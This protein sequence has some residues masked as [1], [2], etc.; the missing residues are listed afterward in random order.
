MQVDRSDNLPNRPYY[1]WVIVSISALTVLVVFGIRLSFTVFFVAL[2][3]E[4]GW[5][6]AGTSLIFSTGMVV[7]ALASTPAGLALDRWGAR[8]T[9]GAGAL[10]LTLGLLLSSRVNHLWQLALTYG[11]IA[12]LGIT[13]LG[14]GLQAGLISRWFR[15][16]LGI[17]IGVAFAGTGLGSLIL[18]PGTERL[19][20]LA[21]WQVAYI[22]LAGLT[23]LLLPLILIFIRQNPAEKGFH[24]DG[25]AAPGNPALHLDQ[26]PGW[27]LTSAARSPTFWLL[28]L[29]SLGAIGP[30]RMLTVHQLA[31][32]VDAGFDRLY[33][34]SNIGLAG[35]VTAGTFVIFGA[36]SD[37]I[38]RRAAYALGSVFLLGAIAILGNLSILSGK[39]WITVYAIFLGVGEG[40][41]S[42]LVT[43]VT[44]DLFP[45][46]ALGAINGAVGAAFGLGAAFFPWLAGYI[47]DRSGVYHLAFT[48]A[49]MAVLISTAALWIA[50]TVAA[51]N[52]RS[53]TPSAG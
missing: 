1:G 30:L 32:I 20:S 4:F 43:A 37:R 47:F 15:K 31:A 52:R 11:V 39:G 34:A 51:R 18:T 21:D 49:I 23:L 12:G 33:A 36:L 48:T 13:I 46:Q 27:T 6:R 7:F 35:A 26:L 19:I 2:I 53:L 42:S 28:I 8:L 50:P 17:A 44:S 22:A 25:Q 29:A 10:I 16:R 45:G 3:E 5:P 41:R 24:I 40:S 9:F 14:L 38:G